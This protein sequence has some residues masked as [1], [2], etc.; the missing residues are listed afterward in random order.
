MN[1]KVAPAS[2]E[3]KMIPPGWLTTGVSAVS[4]TCRGKKHV[5]TSCRRLRVRHVGNDVL[6]VL[7]LLSYQLPF[8]YVK[9]CGH[10]LMRWWIA[11]VQ[12]PPA[13]R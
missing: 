12:S 8:V 9:S 6:V 4:M 1:L 10:T 3:V 7:E 11:D 13:G 2:V 5:T